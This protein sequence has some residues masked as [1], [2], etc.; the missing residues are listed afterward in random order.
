[1]FT[2]WRGSCQVWQLLVKAVLTHQKVRHYCSLAL[3]THLNFYLLN[4]D[5]F[6]KNNMCMIVLLVVIVT[7]IVIGPRSST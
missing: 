6:I 2:E 1:M 7:F 5:L 3:V 4:I